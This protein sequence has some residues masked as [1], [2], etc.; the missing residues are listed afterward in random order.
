MKT[1]RTLGL[2]FIVLIVALFV[3]SAWQIKHGT[4]HA[5][6]SFVILVPV[7]LGL[8]FR[9]RW[10]LWLSVFLGFSSSCLVVGVAVTQSVSRLTGLELGFGP[11]RFADLSVAAIWVFT[12]IYVLVIGAPMVSAIAM[13]RDTNYDA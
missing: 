3:W 10:A 5:D 12:L 9:K 4:G 6:F 8:A 2:Y 13:R 7:A 1:L 11:F